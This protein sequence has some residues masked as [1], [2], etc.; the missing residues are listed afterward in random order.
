MKKIFFF[1][2]LILL[3]NYLYSSGCS[4]NPAIEFNATYSTFVS[5]GGNVIFMCSAYDKD[6]YTDNNN[7]SNEIYDSYIG[8]NNSGFSFW[9]LNDGL[10]LT[11]MSYWKADGT[12][13]TAITGQVLNNV[14]DYTATLNISD[15]GAISPGETGSKDDTDVNVNVDVTVVDI[16]VTCSAPTTII[17]NETVYLLP[18]N[19]DDDN[20]NQIID[21][22]ETE[23]TDEDDLIPLTFTITPNNTRVQ[24]YCH[25]KIY[26]T[27]VKVFANSDRSNEYTLTNNAFDNI[28]IL[29]FN[30][31]NT[32]TFYIEPQYTSIATLNIRFFSDYPIPIPAP[33]PTY[34]SPLNLN[35]VKTVKILGNRINLNSGIA[36]NIENSTPGKV[37]P[38]YDYLNQGV[39][40]FSLNVNG[41]N[42]YR[43]DW[44]S[45]L[46][47]PINNNECDNVEL[48]SNYLLS[49]LIYNNTEFSS[50]NTPSNIYVKGVKPGQATIKG[51]LKENSGSIIHRDEI[52]YSVCQVDISHNPDPLNG[53]DSDFPDQDMPE[54]R[55]IQ[56]DTVYPI[57]L[58][59]LYDEDNTDLDNDYY[60][61][62]VG[63]YYISVYTDVNATNSLVLDN[64]YKKTWIIGQ[65]EMP[66]ILYIKCSPMAFNEITLSLNL[67]K[68]SAPNTVIAK[69]EIKFKLLVN[70][71]VYSLEQGFGN[72]T[73]LWQDWVN[74]IK[75]DSLHT[76]RQCNTI[77]DSSWLNADNPPDGIA[78]EPYPVYD[79]FKHN[80]LFFFQNEGTISKDT[81]Y[82][83]N[84][85]F[86]VPK[87]KKLKIIEGDFFVNNNNLSSATISAT[88]NSTY[89]F[90]DINATGVQ[91]G[92]HS[93]LTINN[94]ESSN[95]YNSVRYR[96]LYIDWK[97]NSIDIGRTY[98]D[99]YVTLRE[100]LKETN[101]STITAYDVYYTNN[102]NDKRLYETC[103]WIGCVAAKGK[104]TETDVFNSI[105]NKFQTMN[106]TSKDG[107][108]LG[109]YVAGENTLGVFTTYNLLR[110]KDGRCGSWARFF[111]NVLACQ[112][113]S[114]DLY[115]FQLK[116]NFYDYGNE[117]IGYFRIEGNTTYQV[118]LIQKFT[119]F[120]KNGKPDKIPFID[121]VINKYK[122]NNEYYYY[123]VTGKYNYGDYSLEHYVENNL[124]VRYT[125]VSNPDN[126]YEESLN[127]NDITLNN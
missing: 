43:S 50:N 81:P 62:F 116:N 18:M 100:P 57:S 41:I 78:Y 48:Y 123:D 42:N 59:L 4:P 115:S 63:N 125:D 7:N 25:A 82:E 120:Q 56:S 10:T 19:D 45:V 70:N 52:L 8:Y 32:Y 51:F 38:K 29:D 119:Q 103:V 102:P 15:L 35:V 91:N 23:N 92:P 114:V 89:S 85:P 33:T 97:Y 106:V 80:Y 5:R 98:H 110:V 111:Q 53:N 75:T 69:D 99:L 71:Y 20:E 54:L 55:Y 27:G 11:D 13:E 40:S 109:Y 26:G 87:D 16:E 64:S 96:K 90:S 68:V 73:V 88:T 2:M 124:K 60:L 105:W 58:K 126:Y 93:V 61:E 17:N 113:V 79:S 3:S 22:T 34:F 76:Y 21:N 72:T 121:H 95:T 104:L 36:D 84:R 37:I 1:F 101:E 127:T 66:E 83:K 117:N 74:E 122:I 46:H 49:N 94:A 39:N 107:E 28:G 31:T 67:K 44:S 14:G 112:G 77:Y 65:D 12:Y 86:L 24:D 9:T 47:I 6:T 108:Q 30:S 118:Q